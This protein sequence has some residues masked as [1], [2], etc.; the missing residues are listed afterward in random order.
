MKIKPYFF[1]E[2]G[3]KLTG[4]LWVLQD[5]RE[6]RDVAAKGGGCLAAEIECICLLSGKK[7][8]NIYYILTFLQSTKYIYCIKI[9]ILWCLVFSQPSIIGDFAPS[10][11]GVSY[12]H[13]S[14][15]QWNKLSLQYSHWFC[16]INYS[17]V[18]LPITKLTDS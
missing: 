4:S 6:V 5:D 17:H 18:L 14:T 15:I 8:T 10:Q 7:F 3:F 2:L 12:I 16:V 13:I 11:N 1:V 9:I